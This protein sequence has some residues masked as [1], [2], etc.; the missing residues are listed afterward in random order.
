[1]K[2]QPPW[3]HRADDGR[4]LRKVYLD[5]REI[6]QAVYADTKEGI[7]ERYRLPLSP[8]S[9]GNLMTETLHGHVEVVEAQE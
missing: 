1:M 7:V 3:I 5:G 2:Q 9:D 6:K 8:G 4:G